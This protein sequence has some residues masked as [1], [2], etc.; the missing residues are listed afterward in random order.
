[1]RREG[2]GGLSRRGEPEKMGGGQ[3]RG[4][5]RGEERIYRYI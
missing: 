1:M 4:E 5:E 2:A 3:E